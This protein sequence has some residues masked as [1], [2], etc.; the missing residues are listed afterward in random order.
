MP[1]TTV[2]C[3]GRNGRGQVGNGNANS[4]QPL[5]VPVSGLSNVASLSL[6]VYHSCA[7]MA[8]R[9]LKCWGQN[10]QGQMGDPSLA[11]S[12]VPTPVPGIAN[13]TSVSTGY[14]HT[15]VA[16]ADGTARCWGQNDYG[17]LGDG[18]VNAAR[19]PVVVQGISTATAISAGGFHTCALLADSSVWCWGEGNFG[20]LGN[21]A[22]ANSPTPV[23]VVGTGMSWTSSNPSVATVDAA[24]LVTGR[25]RGSATITVTDG[26]GNSASTTVSVRE[27]LTLGVLRPGDGGGT[28]TSAPAGINCGT[29]CSGTFLSDSQVTLTAA[30]NALSNFTGWT[31]CESVSGM[32]C[33]V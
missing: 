8:D 29:T 26:Y 6:G 33:T 9:S 31:G 18:T 2:R 21:G 13:V 12:S 30:P 10:D 20:E 7:L 32:T 16:L 27:M 4:P 23:K 3:W 17:A 19:S 15:C 11:F 25:T 14:L 5:P 1:D 22:M 28:V 24:G